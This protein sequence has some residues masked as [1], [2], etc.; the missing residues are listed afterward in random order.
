MGDTKTESRVKERGGM[1][2]EIMIVLQGVLLILAGIGLRGIISIRVYL[3]KLDGRIDQVETWQIGHEK[4][5]DIRSANT[6][7][8]L[9]RLAKCIS[10]LG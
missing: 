2:S 9:D 10:E 4:L 6:Q 3:A 7:E 5:D 1:T 8:R